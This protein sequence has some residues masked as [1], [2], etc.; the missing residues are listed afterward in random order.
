M[1]GGIWCMMTAL[2]EMRCVWQ[3]GERGDEGEV[4]ILQLVYDDTTFG[5]AMHL[6][7]YGYAGDVLAMLYRRKCKTIDSTSSKAQ[8]S[9]F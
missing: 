2:L 9:E 7:I 8:Q 1:K 3:F 4:A 6:A 5:N